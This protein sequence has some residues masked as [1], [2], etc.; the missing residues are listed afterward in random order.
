[1]KPTAG[2]PNPGTLG[3]GKDYASFVRIPGTCSPT[4]P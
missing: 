1:M 2:S 3:D 4:A